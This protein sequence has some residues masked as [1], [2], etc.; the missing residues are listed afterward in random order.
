MFPNLPELDEERLEEILPSI[1]LPWQK[2]WAQQFNL[3]EVLL[4]DREKT[5]YG[6][7]KITEHKNNKHRYN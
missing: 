7:F 6:K 4:D 2:Q 3:N 5:V 1:F